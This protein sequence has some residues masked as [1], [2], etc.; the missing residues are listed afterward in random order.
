[1]RQRAVYCGIFLAS[2]MLVA[3]SLAQPPW[4]GRFDR[5]MADVRG[6]WENDPEFQHDVFTF[7]RVQFDS[8]RDYRGGGRWRTDW[9]DSDVNFS[10][11]LWQLTSLKVNPEPVIVRLDSP[12][13]FRYPFIYMIEPGDIY[14]SPAEITG[15][16]RYLENGG[17]LMVDDF[18]GE[19]QWRHFASEITQVFPSRPIIDLPPDHEIFN[20]VYQ[21]DEPPQIPS[22]N[23]ALGG[24]AS[25]RTWETWDSQ[26]VH[27]RAILDDKQRIMVLICHN[28]DL[29]DGWER[30][31]VDP[32]YFK[33]FS[34]KKAYPLGINIVTYAMTH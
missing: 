34:E 6:D 1:M 33:E 31:G 16:R 15:L 5:R 20:C 4:G 22:I 11:R 14:L 29:G 24:R 18:W 2:L 12:E 8:G 27:Y 13:L 21:L 3:A 17:F 7:A 10:F 9:P 28:T 25:G 26:E 30:E 32:W 19:D 23:Q